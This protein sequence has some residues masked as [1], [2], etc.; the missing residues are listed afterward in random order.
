M[1][2]PLD[3]AANV[4]AASSEALQVIQ[5]IRAPST[6]LLRCELEDIQAWA[7]LGAYFGLKLNGSVAY[8][9]YKMSGFAGDKTTA[10]RELTAA[11]A[12]WNKLVA[13]KSSPSS[14]IRDGVLLG[15]VNMDRHT[16]GFSA[17]TF[18]WSNFTEAVRTDIEL[19]ATATFEPG[20]PT[21]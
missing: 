12:E 7:H 9:R 13:V 8:A 17:M 14:C 21:L 15:D 1:E 10:V 5:G 20:R 16:N 2:S 4:S 11:L 18:S 19:A 3:V 6:G